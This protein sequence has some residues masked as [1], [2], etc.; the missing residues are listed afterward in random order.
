VAVGAVGEFLGN[1][2]AVVQVV[3]V[4]LLVAERRAAE[5]GAGLPRFIW[6]LT[7]PTTRRYC[8]S[9]PILAP[10]LYLKI[11]S[12]CIS[13]QFCAQQMLAGIN[14]WNLRINLF[15][16]L[17]STVRVGCRRKDYGRFPVSASCATISNPD[18]LSSSE[19]RVNLGI[20]SLNHTYL[21]VPDVRIKKW[22]VYHQKAKS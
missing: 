11:A 2:P 14:S 6:E 12:A 1:L 10:V 9:V 4:R 13:F 18:S 22:N 16:R 17:H 5:D 3:Y 20:K 8:D 7:R 15:N 19:T 21:H